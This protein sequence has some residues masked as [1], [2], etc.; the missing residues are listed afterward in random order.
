MSAGTRRS[1]RSWTGSGSSRTTWCQGRSSS[2]ARRTTWTGAVRASWHLSHL[3]PAARP[4]PLRQQPRSHPRHPGP[5]HGRRPQYLG[6]AW[7]VVAAGRPGKGPAWVPSVPS[8]PCCPTSSSALRPSPR[9]PQRPPAGVE[10]S[11]RHRPRRASLPCAQG[12]C[13]A[14]RPAWPAAGRPLCSSCLRLPSGAPAA[15]SA[16]GPRARPDHRRVP[17]GHGPTSPQWRSS[18]GL[19]APVPWSRAAS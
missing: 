9:P 15:P 10:R 1:H 12:R 4:P 7:P 13:G 8:A 16:P 5:G 6:R 3:A 2:L 14:W 11:R 19:A 18:G 17:G